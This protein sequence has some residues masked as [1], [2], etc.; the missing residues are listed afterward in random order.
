[1]GYGTC[2]N[3]SRLFV[4]L[5]R[6]SN[7]PARTIWGIVHGFIVGHH[8]WAEF[9][10]ENGVWHAVDLA[11]TK[12]FE[13]D[14]TRY[15]DLIYG[16]E[17]NPLFKEIYGPYRMDEAYVWL[18]TKYDYSADLGYTIAADDYPAE[19]TYENIYLMKDFYRKKVE[20]PF[21]SEVRLSV[22]SLFP[23]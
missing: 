20:Y 16:S 1:M 6:A 13:L 22:E 19:C 18:S 8:E 5:C 7:V 10:D 12:A 17:E 21:F 23:R 11:Y 4:A 15:L 9:L 14:D 2:V 3:M